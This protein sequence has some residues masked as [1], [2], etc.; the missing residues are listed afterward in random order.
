MVVALTNRVY[1][2]DFLSM[3]VIH[4]IPTF[5]FPEE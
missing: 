5:R 1:L 2:V 3:E 4:I